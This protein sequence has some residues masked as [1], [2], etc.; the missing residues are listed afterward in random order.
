MA[1]RATIFTLLQVGEQNKIYQT[2][3]ERFMCGVK[4]VTNISTNAQREVAHTELTWY[5]IGYS[6]FTLCVVVVVVVVVYLFVAVVGVNT[7]KYGYSYCC[8]TPRFETTSSLIIWSRM[9]VP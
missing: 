6:Q 4:K 9:R 5:C 8:K 1:R 7:R 3:P 2:H